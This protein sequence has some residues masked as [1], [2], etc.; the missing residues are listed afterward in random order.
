MGDGLGT[1]KKVGLVLSGGSG[2]AFFHVGALVVIAREMEKAKLPISY[3]SA[4]SAGALAAVKFLEVFPRVDELEAFVLRYFA[5]PPFKRKKVGKILKERSLF[6]STPLWELICA[7]DLQRV[8][9]SSTELHVIATNV[10]SRRERVFSN[11]SEDADVFRKGVFASIAL[12]RIFDPVPINAEGDFMDGG[13]VNPVPIENAVH[14]GCDTVV[15]VDGNPRRSLRGLEHFKK[16]IRIILMRPKRKLL[17]IGLRWGKSDVAR[18]IGEGKKI[19]EYELQK[20]RL[21]S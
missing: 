3:I 12:P 17:A 19:A 8:M 7:V 5:R 20:A 18:L 14:A 13:I 21:I 2:K 1:P 4:V 6:D 16:K 11:K 10:V 9:N 15:V